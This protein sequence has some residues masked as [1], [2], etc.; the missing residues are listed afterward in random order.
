MINLL[1][2]KKYTM[3][4][5][6]IFIIFWGVALPGK[7]AVA[8]TISSLFYAQNY[9][10]PNRHFGGQLET[11]WNDIVASGVKYM[12][13]GGIAYDAV[14]NSPAG[15]TYLWTSADLASGTG[16]IIAEMRSYNIEPIIQVPIDITKTIAQNATAAATLVNDINN[17]YGRNIIYWEIGNEPNGQYA[18]TNH[19]D[20]DTAI[21]HYIKNVST[22]MKGVSGQSGIKIIGPSLSFYDAA[23]YGHFLGGANDISGSGTNGYYIDYI[24][25]HTYPFQNE[26]YWQKSAA[27]CSGSTAVT[28]TDVIGYIE[29]A[30][31]FKANL[32]DLVSKISAVG[33]TSTLKISIT[34]ANIS[35][36]QDRSARGV[37]DLGPGSFLGGQFWAEMM[38]ASMEKGVA[39]ISFWSVIEGSSTNT[40]LSDIGYIGSETTEKRSTYWHYK[41]LSDNFKGTYLPNVLGNTGNYKAFG[42]SNSATNEIGVLIMNQN[43]GSSPTRATDTHTK[44]FN[45]NFSSATPSG[46][47]DMKFSFAGG[48]IS[49]YHC[50]IT[51]ETTMLLVFDASTGALKRKETYSL[52][53][54][55]RTE[56]TGTLTNITNVSPTYLYDNYSDPSPLLS[57]ITIGTGATVTAGFNKTFTAT[58][59][60]LLNGPYSSNG[61]TLNLL[62]DHNTCYSNP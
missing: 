62:V 18:G 10:D 24:D 57:D 42:Y 23:R 12:R 19:Y 31:K 58:N 37:T 29:A 28:R 3:K 25:F 56:D 48:G 5:C 8:Q 6:I 60:I 44:T 59:S 2:L 15:T 54:A 55:L 34:E 17:T 9:W 21:A 38:A 11:Y 14:N 36:E 4:K 30:T 39:L 20:A 49:E 13:I 45:I 51:V 41:L 32:G 52:R 27:N 53:D 35:Y 61:K 7:K 1:N 16:S 26:C 46:T 47:Y 43:L 22:A 40:Y 33:R 50:T